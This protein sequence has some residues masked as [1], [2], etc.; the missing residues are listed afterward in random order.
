MELEQIK[1]AVE[2][3]ALLVGEGMPRPQI[4]F[5]LLQSK[6]E[7]IW[8]AILALGGAPSCALY[9]YPARESRVIESMSVEIDGV[10]VRIQRNRPPTTGDM[11]SKT[12]TDR[13]ETVFVVSDV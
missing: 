10:E 8:N 11:E 7:G 5:V 2:H 4:S 12:N 9:E 1:Q 3:L 6:E 13:H